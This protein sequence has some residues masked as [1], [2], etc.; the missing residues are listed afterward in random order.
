MNT[1]ESKPLLQKG[2][3]ISWVKVKNKEG[4]TSKTK[5]GKRSRKS[6]TLGN[7][8]HEGR[9]VSLQNEGGSPYRISTIVQ[10]VKQISSGIFQIETENS[11]YEARIQQS[12]QLH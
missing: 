8:V 1:N 2:E 11:L 9:V 10:S 7:D 3:K 12:A 6:G 5:P 4:S